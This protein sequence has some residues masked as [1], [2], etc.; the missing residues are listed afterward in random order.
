MQGGSL[1]RCQASTGF[2]HCPGLQL[3]TDISLGQHTGGC[4]GPRSTLLAYIQVPTNNG[5]GHL[6][7]AASVDFSEYTPASP[8]WSSELL[9]T[10]SEPDLSLPSPHMLKPRLL[11]KKVTLLEV[12]SSQMWLAEMKSHWSRVILIHCGL[13]RGK[14][15]H[16]EHTGDC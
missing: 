7:S 16:R 15:G 3:V 2:A 4:Y 5:P 14:C 13:T 8:L 6:P 12:G 1:S 10:L 11:T 9:S